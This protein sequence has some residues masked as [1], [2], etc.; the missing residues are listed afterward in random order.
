MRWFTHSFAGSLAMDRKVDRDGPLDADALTE[1]TGD[2]S[3][4]VAGCRVDPVSMEQAVRFIT[5]SASNGGGRYVCLTNA[6]TAVEAKRLPEL[7]RAVDEASLSVPDGMPLV[8]SL[9]R[10]GFDATEKVT[11]IEYIPQV[12]KAGLEKNLRHFFFGGAP[13]VAEKAAE[14][15]QQ[16][17]PGVQI[18]GTYCPPFDPSG[19]WDVVDVNAAL[20]ASEAHI[21]W[22]GVGAPKQEL[23]MHRVRN[24]IDVPVMVGVGAAF[25]FLAGSKRPAPRVLSRLGLEW[26]FRLLSE[27]RRLWRRYLIG[28]LTFARLVWRDRKRHGA[29]C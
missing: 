20:R 6:Y 2:R 19:A 13:G 28:N 16:R 26:L 27:P 12:A 1:V 10:R 24:H 21:V 4:Y 17:V 14:G 11:G 15:L 9:R 5:D 18:A 29:G 7:R 8:W 23:W 22:V 25:D 3:Q